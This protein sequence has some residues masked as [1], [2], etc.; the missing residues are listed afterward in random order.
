LSDRLREILDELEALFLDEGFAKLTIGDMAARLRCSRST[1]YELAPTRDELILIVVDRRFRRLGRHVRER[2]DEVHDPLERLR[3]LLAT[4]TSL[5]MRST[6]AHFRTDAVRQ[7]AVDRLITAH[8]RYATAL[9]RETLEAGI[10]TGRF[11]KLDAR[12]VAEIIDAALPRIQD[13]RLL[14]ESGLTFDDTIGELLALVEAG[15][16]DVGASGTPRP[17]RRQR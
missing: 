12:V 3:I 13:P 14:E 11:R 15:V 5:E 6:S 7:P 1:L 9:I 2:L 16:L 4:E 17:R 10:A 8:Y